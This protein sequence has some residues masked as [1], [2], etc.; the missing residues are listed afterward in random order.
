MLSCRAWCGLT[1][2]SLVAGLSRPAL[3]SGLS[4]ATLLTSLSLFALLAV[5][6]LTAL[7]SRLSPISNFSRS[8]LLPRVPLLP[9][10]TSLALRP[11]RSRHC[12]WR[13]VHL[14]PGQK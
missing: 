11:G 4:L 10:L 13:R 5:S 2:S 7:I 8:T 12:R 1:L 14:A 6:S 9:G 3:I